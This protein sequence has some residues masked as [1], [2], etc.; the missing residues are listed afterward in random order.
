MIRSTRLHRQ[1]T[2]DAETRKGTYVRHVVDLVHVAVPDTRSSR[3]SFK[4]FAF[5]FVGD[6]RCLNRFEYSPCGN[7]PVL[8]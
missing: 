1:L 3:L 6:Y 5:S 7:D 8:S 2:V 4:T